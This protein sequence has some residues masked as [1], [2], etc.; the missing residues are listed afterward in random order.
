MSKNIQQLQ[1]CHNPLLVR[2][3]PIGVPASVKLV[4]CPPSNLSHLTRCGLVMPWILINISSG[5]GLLSDRTKPLPDSMSKMLSVTILDIDAKSICINGVK[6]YTKLYDIIQHQ[7]MI[8]NHIGF[9]GLY[10]TII[11]NYTING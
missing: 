5:Y 1:K 6:E 7:T 3:K 8:M 4:Y 11:S 10:C 9:S 2:D